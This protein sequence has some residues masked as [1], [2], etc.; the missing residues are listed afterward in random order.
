[1][2]NDSMGLVNGHGQENIV[3]TLVTLVMVMVNPPLYN[4]GLTNDLT[5]TRFLNNA[6]VYNKLLRK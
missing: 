2:F 4:R 1:M 6:W 3:M 5:M